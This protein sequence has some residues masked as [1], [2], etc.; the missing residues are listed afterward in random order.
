MLVTVLD[1]GKT[2]LVITTFVFVMML[3]VDYVNVASKGHMSRFVRGGRWRQYLIAGL[4]G[5]TPGCLGAFMNVYLFLHGYISFGAV[6]AGMVATSGDEAFVMFAMFPGRAL[7]L[8]LALLLL[9]IPLGWLVDRALGATRPAGMLCRIPQ[10]HEEEEAC[11]WFSRAHW[12]QDWKRVSLLR[13]GLGASLLL[14][15]AIAVSG[16][17]GGGRS[18]VLALLAASSLAVVMSVPEHCLRD[19]IGRLTTLA[20]REEGKN[21]TQ[22]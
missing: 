22:E 9:G 17:P 15:V 20:L 19:H 10:I 16:T 5:A 8:T 18:V 3:W 2:S 13:L 4:L 12:R 6:T 14:I 21:G 7:I 1:A 11:R